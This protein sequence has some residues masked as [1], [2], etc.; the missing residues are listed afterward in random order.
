MILQ[1]FLVAW[2]LLCPVAV[3]AA[4]G[5][6]AMDRAVLA[7]Y[8]AFRRG[9]PIQLEKQADVLRGHLLEPYAD[10]WRLKLQLEDATQ[11]EVEGFFARHSGRYVA[12]MMRADWLRV[13]GKRGDW[14]QFDAE[15][16]ALDEAD[17]E[18]RC[19]ALASRLARN[20]A[21]AVAP[22]MLVW[23]ESGPLPEGCTLLAERMVD[24]GRIAVPD[25]WARVRLLFEYGETAEA[26]RALGY[27]PRAEAP[28]ERD[29]VTAA[30]RPARLLERRPLRLERRSARE[31]AVLAAIRLAREDAQ[32][33]AK[34]M[35]KALGDALPEAERRYVWGKIAQEAARQHDPQALEWYALAHGAPLDDVQLAWKARAAL[36][37]GSWQ[38]VI[39][40]I[41]AMSE[42]NRRE[43]VWTYWYARALAAQGNDFGA[44]VRYFAIS[45][46]GGFYN[47]LAAE[48]LGE[49]PAPS[50]GGYE[51]EE[52][53]V[54]GARRHPGIERALALYR[55]GLRDEAAREWAY[56]V[57]AM[58]DGQLIA[59]AEL[60]RR[61]GVY[62]RAINTAGRTTYLHN[63]RLRYVAPYR[64]VF[65][66]HARAQGVDAAWLLAVARQESRFATEARSGAG[67]RGLMQI[68][69]ATARWIARRSGMRGYRAEHAHEVE[70]NITLGARYLKRVL[71]RFGSPVL[72]LAA[73]NAGPT[74]AQRWRDAG[75]L[76]GA[77][78]AETIPFPETRDY[79]KKV[80]SS[81]VFYSALLQETVAPLKE[82]LG[83]VTGREPAGRSGGRDR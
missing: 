48:E 66:E 42:A 82:R 61:E 81:A 28:D 68:M 73:Y 6:D 11:D 12:E 30:K 10:Y 72:A 53:E 39:E 65:E 83:V 31:V 9:N 40:A 1:R 46:G 21:S 45:Q 13:L 62:E 69:P 79:V 56:T 52:V 54:E 20:D 16:G 22:A 41:D 63:L 33:A 7:A 26:K 67:A 5:A 74:R 2:G 75:P 32:S 27:L 37:R 29:L 77:I 49:A 23:R 76:E 78:Y 55:L 70:T 35:Q 36:R 58:D 44:Q 25:I 19:Y 38:T 50:E 57:R 80:M 71:D 43:S 3:H 24:T 64:D 47:V 34:T 18:I 17:P 8:D 15:L 4:P 60:A 59:A 51:P 14:V